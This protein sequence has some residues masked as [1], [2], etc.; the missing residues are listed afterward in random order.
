MRRLRP[1]VPFLLAVAAFLLAALAAYGA[2]E[3]RRIDA[4]LR[5]SDAA[6]RVEPS[7]P[8][9]WDVDTKAPGVENVLGVDDDVGY[10]RAARRFFV[11]R[12]AVPDPFGSARRASRAD[13]Q[14]ALAGVQE[15]SAPR[16][17]KSKAA[18]FEG[19]L[20]LEDAIGDQRNGPALLRGSMDHFRRAIRLDPAN[21]EAPYN[22]ELLLMLLQPERQKLAARYGV[23]MRGRD[24]AGAAALGKGHGY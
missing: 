17:A 8:G 23:S 24:I 4:E 13:A 19:V 22:L 3:A 9:L 18:N 2:R 21:Q 7:R 10:R 12:A 16:R 5:R 6:F 14:L 11:L 20:V 1:A 15:S